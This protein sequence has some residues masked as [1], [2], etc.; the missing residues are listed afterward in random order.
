MDQLL[1]QLPQQFPFRF[2]N[3][4]E[5]I[6][7]NSIW[8]KGLITRNH[9]LIQNSDLIP[10]TIA[11]EASLQA[12]CLWGVAQNQQMTLSSFS[13]SVVR[14]K[15]VQFGQ[16]LKIDEPF[17]VRATCLQD[18]EEL[19]CFAVEMS[20]KGKSILQGECFLVF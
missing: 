11:L 8:A 17:S 16:Q 13:P 1:D 18:V 6:D 14:L 10:F 7:G 9:P 2:I 4:I 15:K 19:Y 5:K 20:Q 3:Q 12:S